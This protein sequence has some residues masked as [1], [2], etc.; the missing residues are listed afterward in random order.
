MTTDNNM[1]K[2]TMDNNVNTATTPDNNVTTKRTTK[3]GKGSI[4]Q[5]RKPRSYASPKL[6]PTDLPTYLL[7]GVAKKHPVYMERE[8]GDNL[9][10]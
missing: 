1:T 8:I 2:A 10:I 3:L 9:K 7:T 6:R 4:K 5:A